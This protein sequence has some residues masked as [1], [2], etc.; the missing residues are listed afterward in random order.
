MHHVWIRSPSIHTSRAFPHEDS[1]HQSVEWQELV[2]TAAVLSVQEREA[3][4]NPKPPAEVL[5]MMPTRRTWALLSP[6]SSLPIIP[7]HP[8]SATWVSAGCDFYYNVQLIIN[9]LFSDPIYVAGLSQ[10]TLKTVLAVGTLT[11]L[12]SLVTMSP[13]SQSHDKGKNRGGWFVFLPLF[14]RATSQPSAISVGIVQSPVS[15]LTYVIAFLR[16]Q[17]LKLWL[18]SPF[19]AMLTWWGSFN[20]RLLNVQ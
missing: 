15:L 14:V 5:T 12:Q 6:C 11:L 4:W 17:L 2:F 7:H 18:L 1:Y 13:L 3:R 19:G 20:R 9:S 10:C 16:S 8:R